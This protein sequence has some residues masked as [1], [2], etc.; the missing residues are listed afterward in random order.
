MGIQNELGIDPNEEVAIAIDTMLLWLK[1]VPSPHLVKGKLSASAQRGK[2]VFIKAECN[3]CHPAPL[4][5]D[6]QRPSTYSPRGK[7]FIDTYNDNSGEWDTPTL[8]ECWR[9][10]PYGH[11]G[12]FIKIE[13][14]IRLR[15]HSDYASKLS[16]TSQDFKDLIEYVLSL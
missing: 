12:S 10:G 13:D 16:E 9:T 2:Q 14:F 11:I 6:G 15:D 1:P 5:T 3:Y 7:V 8:I 4:F